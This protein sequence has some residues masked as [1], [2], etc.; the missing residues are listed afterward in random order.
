MTGTEK[1][2][3]K[4]QED[5]QS[6]AEVIRENGRSAARSVLDEAKAACGK[7]A[8]EAEANAA[9]YLRLQAERS[10]LNLAMERRQAL[11]AAKG[12]AIEEV[13]TAAK[14]DLLRRDPA[15]YFAFLLK[16]LKKQESIGDG[17]LLLSAQDLAR[18]PADFEKNVEEIAA[19]KGG[20]LVLAKEAAAIEGGFIIHYSGTSENCS[21]E[22]I[23][24]SEGENLKDIVRRILFTDAEAR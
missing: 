7:I 21:L 19:A 8:E 2:I 12:E 6:E 23:F 13:L 24:A 3:A 14:E 10:R 22:A 5:A 1:I 15:A 11:L 16:L 20:K 4:I 18:M 17:V 9:D